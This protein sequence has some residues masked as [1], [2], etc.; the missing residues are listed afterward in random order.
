MS[1]K[2]AASSVT[3][4]SHANR[5][6][7]GQDFCRAGSIRIA[8]SEYFIGLVADGAGSTTDG[9]RGAEIACDTLHASILDTLRQDGSIA[10]IT[11]DMIRTWVTAAREA[12]SAE[13]QGKGK[14]IRD[15]A[16]TLLGAAA[17][18]SHALFFQ[19]GDG[20]IVIRVDSA[21]QTVFWPEQGEYANTTFFLS[22]ETYRDTLSIRHR[23]GSP[24]EIAL[25]S[26]GLQNLALSFA[27]KQAHAGFFQP[28]FAALRND[29]ASGFS[30]FAGQL[31]RFLLRDDVSARSDDDKTLVLA[32]QG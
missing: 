12:I 3:G 29:P 25:F 4:S 23:D 24:D 19:I 6:E 9:G 5:G 2:V 32:V 21:Y 26:D 18:D 27:Q 20:A 8:D 30:D 7:S 1:W 14:R 13:A 15:Y 11:D 17:G 16:C 31:E 22:D 28:L 10:A